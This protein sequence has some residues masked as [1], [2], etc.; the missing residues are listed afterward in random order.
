MERMGFPSK[1]RMWIQECLSTAR[2]SV[3]LNGSPSS[4]FGVGRGL[5]QGDPLAPFL[6]LIV[7]EG[8]HALM[9]K[10]VEFQVFVGYEAGQEAVLVS[11]LQYADDTLV[12]GEASLQN[13]WAIKAIFQLFKVVAGLKVNFHKSKLYGINVDRE[14]L[15][16]M[17]LFLNCTVGSNSCHLHLAQFVGLPICSSVDR[18]RWSTVWMTVLWSLWIAR[19]EAI[20]SDKVILHSN[21]LKLIQLR[22]W[23]W[24]KAKDLSFQY[25]YSSWVGSPAVCLNFMDI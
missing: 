22:S 23:K 10:A 8:F 4:E 3:L 19:N 9:A 17:T 7:A 5:R 11:H 14:L 18:L 2:V 1:W 21:L 6:F 20:F 25:P 12:I 24:L 13:I 15:D 16:G